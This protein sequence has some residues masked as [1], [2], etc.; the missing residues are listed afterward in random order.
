MSAIKTSGSDGSAARRSSTSI[1]S[2]LMLSTDSTSVG[3]IE[4][5][6][7]SRCYAILICFI[8]LLLITI[9]ARDVFLSRNFISSIFFE[10]LCST[11][12]ML[13]I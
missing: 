2:E 1:K 12:M 8:N 13:A 11:K 9:S 7:P 5:E 4:N 3:S 10:S 6:F